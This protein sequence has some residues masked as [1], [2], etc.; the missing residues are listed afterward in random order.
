MRFYIQIAEL[1]VDVVVETN[2]WAVVE[3]TLV[4]FSLRSV[5]LSVGVL[6]RKESDVLECSVFQGLT[7]QV[8]DLGMVKEQM[9][10]P[11]GSF[12][13]SI[14][15]HI[16]NFMLDAALQILQATPTSE[17]M[18]ANG[19]YAEKFVGNLIWDLCNVTEKLLLQSLE[20]R[21]C[22]IGFFLPVIFKALV[23]HRSFDIS[24]HGQTC[25]LSR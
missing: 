11:G 12:P 14:S 10:S 21:S 22:M 1:F 3:A 23:F 24:I 8:N 17:L 25:T 6:Q 20:H 16:L 19:C 7:D 4:P 13:L 2:S 5:G 18:V 15:C 9:L